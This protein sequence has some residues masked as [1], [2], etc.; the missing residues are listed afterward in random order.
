MAPGG[1]PPGA[2]LVFSCLMGQPEPLG[3]VALQ[4]LGLERELQALV[5]REMACR[6]RRSAREFLEQQEQPTELGPAPLAPHSFAHSQP[7]KE[8]LPSA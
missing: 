8:S 6:E 4:V 3:R 7:T 1:N 5:L 2:I